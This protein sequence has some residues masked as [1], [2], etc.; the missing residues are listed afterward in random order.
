MG[1]GLNHRTLLEPWLEVSLVSNSSLW[2]CR[3][4]ALLWRRRLLRSLPPHWQRLRL[5][6]RPEPPRP[7]PGLP[8]IA[9]HRPA[10]PKWPERKRPRR[11]AGARHEAS[12]GAT[13]GCPGPRP[14][15]RGR[16]LVH[17]APAQPDPHRPRAQ[18]PRQ[19]STGRAAAA[20]LPGKAEAGQVPALWRL[21]PPLP[22]AAHA[23]WDA[24]AVAVRGRVHA[25]AVPGLRPGPGARGSWAAGTCPRRA[26]GPGSGPRRQPPRGA[27]GQPPGS[28]ACGA[29]HLRGALP[30]APDGRQ[31]L[32]ILEP[33]RRRPLGSAQ[34]HG[35]GDEP[36]GPDPLP[37]VGNTQQHA[38][39]RP[40]T[41]CPQFHCASLHFPSPYPQ[42]APT[43]PCPH[44][45]LNG[46]NVKNPKVTG[47]RSSFL[48]LEWRRQLPVSFPVQPI[49]GIEKLLCQHGVLDTT[50]QT[51]H[52]IGGTCGRGRTTQRATLNSAAG[53]VIWLL[54]LGSFMHLWLT[55][56]N[57][58]DENKISIVFPSIPNL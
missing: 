40:T 49:K 45:F 37:C 53:Y 7:G 47:S 35:P 3:F 5:Q 1:E 44:P 23:Q 22:L 11:P 10:G 20:G 51:C 29:P 52:P 36:R 57:S 33:A 4:T 46:L 14:G 17:R 41:G 48:E 25:A 55:G 54:S 27:E 42:P 16:P 38:L 15:A 43:P 21:Q 30:R 39:G 2:L 19:C 50:V 18:E 6:W 32:G 24:V 58:I 28:Q 13:P 31:T 26:A 34:P 8:V 56:R 12:V 9:R